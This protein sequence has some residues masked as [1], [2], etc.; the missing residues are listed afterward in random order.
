LFYDIEKIN[1]EKFIFSSHKIR[2]IHSTFSNLISLWCL[3]HSHRHSP[4]IVS[5]R[6][7]LQLIR[8]NLPSPIL[9]IKFNDR[10]RRRAYSGE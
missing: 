2:G 10:K 7:K 1:E 9:A 8:L 3:E 4:R 5:D 6:Q